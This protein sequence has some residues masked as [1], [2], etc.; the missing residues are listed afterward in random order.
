[1]ADTGPYLKLFEAVCPPRTYR[2]RVSLISSVYPL[3][4]AI[5]AGSEARTIAVLVERWRDRIR[6][7]ECHGWD[8]T[9][10]TRGSA[11]SDDEMAN[12]RKWRMLNCPPSSIKVQPAPT[13]CHVRFA[14]PHCWGRNAQWH[15][16]SPILQQGAPLARF[17]RHELLFFGST[18]HEP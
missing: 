5:K 15:L 3:C 10:E 7:L 2:N 16:L 17:L 12:S 6:H 4:G 11:R 9:A 14:C 18:S 8:Q 1:M 13:P